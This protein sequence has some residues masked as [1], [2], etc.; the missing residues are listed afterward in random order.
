MTIQRFLKIAPKL[1]RGSAPS[2]KD[3]ASLQKKLGV[4][5][6]VSLDQQTGEVIDRA[7]KLLGIKHIKI[8]MSP[9][10]SGRAGLIRLLSH[11]LKETFLEGGPVFIH[12]REGKDRTGLVSAILQCKYLGIK[13]EKAIREAK[14]L[15]FGIGVDPKTVALYEKIIQNCKPEKN[16]DKNHADIV[17]NER[18]YIGDNRDS[19][20]D[21]V[22][23]G[24]FSIP[25]D[26]TKQFPMDIVYN[27]DERS[28]TRENFPDEATFK[29]SNDPGS[30][31][32]DVG[33][34]NNDSGSYGSGFVLNPGGFIFD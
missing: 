16:V 10:H 23:R 17:S 3:V 29:E 33:T 25:L 14:S 9:E 24:D 20:L 26:Y 31:I 6:I 19:F 11:N 4:K 18:Q 27:N 13:P 28:L 15:G 30:E 1:Y 7:C 22:H 34:Y 2:P 5:K 8:Y 12:C 21:E 32:P